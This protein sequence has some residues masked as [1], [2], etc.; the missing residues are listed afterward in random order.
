MAESVTFA[1][2][3][4][5]PYGHD[6]VRKH[7]AQ[8]RP[9]AFSN[10]MLLLALL[11]AGKAAAGAHGLNAGTDAKG[12]RWVGR[13]GW[14]VF[15]R[16]GAAE[17]HHRGVAAVR[18][19]RHRA[20]CCHLLEGGR[21]Q[22]ECPPPPSAPLASW[23]ERQNLGPASTAGSRT[24]TMRAKRRARK[25]RTAPT[26]A[27]LQKVRP[28]SSPHHAT[29][30]HATP[31]HTMLRQAKPS[32]A[33]PQYAALMLADGNAACRRRSGRAAS[34]RRGRACRLGPRMGRW[35]AAAGGAAP[36]GAACPGR[37]G[38]ARGGRGVPRRGCPCVWHHLGGWW[39]CCVC[40]GR[41]HHRRMQ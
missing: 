15:G 12:D 37:A 8:G 7:Q 17:M 5:L 31:R 39:P 41:G 3:N 35:A 36:G 18:R 33:K 9:L 34:R 38:A 40:G 23:R 26:R 25:P 20:A 19:A 24:A 6:A 32:Q 22:R 2:P 29:P 16:R 13:A 4:W 1:P 28:L 14:A 10:D 11:R 30:R 21:A 27:H